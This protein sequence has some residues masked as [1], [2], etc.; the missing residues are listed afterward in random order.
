MKLKKIKIRSGYD[1]VVQVVLLIWAFLSIFPMY[2]MLTFSLKDN[3]EIYGANPVGLPQV[4]RFENYEKALM[5]GK[6][7]TYFMNSVI[8]T[9]ITVVFVAVF[10]IMAAYAITRMRWKLSRFTEA[11]FIFGIT[12][13]LHSALLPVFLLLRDMSLLSTR[14]ALILP[15]TAFSLPMAIMI[16]NGLMRSIPRELDEA[17]YIEGCGHYKVFFHIIFP[18]MKPAIATVAIFTFLHSWN[19]LM[20]AQIYISDSTLKTITAGIQTLVGEHSTDWGPVGAG[21]V[22]ATVPIVIAYLFLS[23][24]VQESMT[25][26]SLKG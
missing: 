21:M 23:K 20:F 17:A 13:P 22:I 10:S 14:W 16:C 12:I 6:M 11:L 1:V 15:Y 3:A 4:W 18:L 2:W 5:S 25:A 9:T 24:Q 7:G 26:G 8:V 19:E